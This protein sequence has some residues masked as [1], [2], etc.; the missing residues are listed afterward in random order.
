MCDSRN[1]FE[2]SRQTGSLASSLEAKRAPLGSASTVIE[3]SF[4]E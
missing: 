3:I 2:V 1:F 4:K